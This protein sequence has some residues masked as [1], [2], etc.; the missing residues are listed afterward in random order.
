MA[1]TLRDL[2]DIREVCVISGG[3]FEQFRSQ[4]L[5]GLG[6]DTAQLGR[7]H[8]MPTCGTRYMRHDGADWVPVY[9]R[10]LTQSER[11]E[12]MRVVEEEAKNLGLWE[13]EP[14]GHIIEDRGSQITFSALG[15]Q[16]PLDAKKAWD[17]SGEKKERLRAAVAARLPDLEVRSGGSTSVDITRKGVDK[18]YGITELAQQTGIDI[19]QMLFIGDRLDPGGN[20]YPVIKTGI[21]THAVSGWEDTV[22][23][24]AN[25]VEKAHNSGEHVQ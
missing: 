4:L 13:A 6:A 21:D 10:D 9:V 19:G 1:V 14:W 23:F 7:L 18:A 5:A 20:D 12:A 11:D 16:A 15:Q 17:P 24:V 2:L 25:F 8:L 22:Q 3:N